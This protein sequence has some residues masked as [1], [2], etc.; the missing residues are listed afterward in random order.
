MHRNIS[1]ICNHSDLSMLRHG[2]RRLLP[3]VLVDTLLTYLLSVSLFAVCCSTRSRCC[4]SRTSWSSATSAVRDYQNVHTRPC[5]TS[6]HPLTPPHP[7]S[8]RFPRDIGGGIRAAMGH[9]QLG[10]IDNWLRHIRDVYYRHF[11]TIEDG[12][13]TQEEK[14]DELCMLNIRQSVC[15]GTRAREDGAGAGAAPHPWCRS[16]SRCAAAACARHSEWRAGTTGSKSAC[17]RRRPLA[18]RR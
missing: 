11:D 10:L 8:L 3:P 9:Q 7:Q 18:A 2:G 15:A 14:E 16:R 12:K 5:P 6:R 17:P 4:A 1:N 13:K